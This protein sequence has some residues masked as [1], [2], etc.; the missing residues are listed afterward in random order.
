LRLLITGG[1][2]FIGRYTMRAAVARGDEVVVYDLAVPTGEP[3]AGVQYVKGE[4]SSADDVFATLEA[5]RPTAILHLAA[6]VGAPTSMNAPIESMR[7]NVEG[8]IHLLEAVQRFASVRVVNLSSEETYGDFENEVIDEDHVQRPFTPYGVSK[9]AAEGFCRF[10]RRV[11]GVDVVTART[12]WVYGAG[13]TRLRPPGSLLEP[14]AR[15]EAVKHPFGADFV[16]DYTCVYDVADGL[17]QLASAPYLSHD[18]YHLSSGKATG[19]DELLS[20]IRE[21][22]PR[23]SVHMGPGPWLF[24]PGCPAPRKGAMT[25]HRAYRDVGY[26]PSFTLKDGLERYLRDMNSGERF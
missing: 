4:L 2:G 19:T 9:A 10:Y 25:Y 20:M 22:V 23:A 26:K 12:S 1:A 7:V 15:G 24:A 5:Y 17:L 6:V 11:R 21:L 18:A 14:A 16:V 8:T 3:P 13:L